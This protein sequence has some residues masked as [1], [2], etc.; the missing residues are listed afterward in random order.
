MIIVQNAQYH[1]AIKTGALKKKRE[2]NKLAEHTP[3]QLNLQHNTPTQREYQLGRSL[4]K[5]STTKSA[6]QHTNPKRRPTRSFSQLVL[7]DGDLVSGG[8]AQL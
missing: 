6:A 3:Q 2:P 8:D 5:S 7:G 4:L 1:K